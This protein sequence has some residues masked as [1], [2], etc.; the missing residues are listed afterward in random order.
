[1]SVFLKVMKKL[2]SAFREKP[3]LK[4]DDFELEHFLFYHGLVG[5]SPE[6]QRKFKDVRADIR[7][8]VESKS[9]AQL[10]IALKLL[11]LHW[12]EKLKSIA[13]EIKDKEVLI[14]I[15]APERLGDTE[16]NNN[17]PLFHEHWKVRANAAKMLAHLKATTKVEE[18]VNSLPGTR[19][20]TK[21]AF[22]HLVYAL[23]RLGEKSALEAIE[24]FLVDEDPWIQVDAAGARAQLCADP[25]D[26]P[27]QDAIFRS[28][29]FFDY[30]AVQISKVIPVQSFLE[31][32]GET[33]PDPEIDKNEIRQAGMRLVT[34]VCQAGSGSF[35]SEV[36]IERGLDD[37]S[38]ELADELSQSDTANSASPISLRAALDLADWLSNNGRSPHAAI[39][40]K[41]AES[42]IKATTSL[43]DS[44]GLIESQNRSPFESAT[45]EAAIYC[46]GRLNQTELAPALYKALKKPG[47]ASIKDEILEAL[48]KIG[49]QT[50]DCQKTGADILLELAKTAV[51]LE[52]RTEISPSAQPV[53]EEEE[54]PARLYFRVL[55]ALGKTAQPEA[56]A[57]LVTATSDHA[58]DKRNRALKSLIE[59]GD[60]KAEHIAA[61]K[62]SLIER[63]S[64]LSAE[65]RTTAVDGI[66]RLG[67]LEGADRVLEL[68]AAREVSLAN[69][70]LETLSDLAMNGNR[71]AI[72]EKLKTKLKSGGNQY[73]RE[74]LNKLLENIEKHQAKP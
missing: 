69:K 54:E 39:L 16:T 9:S 64:D 74:K 19:E 57:Y 11:P 49:S 40:E 65:V 63:M 48:S 59:I 42:Y 25:T 24:P 20:N 56:V 12:E 47:S 51:D 8:A 60:N 17:F 61:F 32:T 55:K 36:V 68:T 44:L 58:P 43:G 38:R 14:E 26:K 31:K 34:G 70:A 62:N 50:E 6:G 41:A 1:M 73:H 67:V 7:F 4:P 37:L 72:I 45:L 2:S 3:T 28:G 53:I 10:A 33:D 35:P 22:C 30:A 27:L 46:A 13:D 66:G 52:E 18:L 71:D 29:K 21:M 23:G 15:L 5:T